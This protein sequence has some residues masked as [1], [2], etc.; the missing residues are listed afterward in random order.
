MVAYQN[1]KKVNIK[2]WDTAGMEQFMSITK[3]YYKRADC[4]VFVYDCGNANTF[5]NID[6]W[7]DSVN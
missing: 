6:R 7:L 3:S 5:D 1:G 2:V 4:V